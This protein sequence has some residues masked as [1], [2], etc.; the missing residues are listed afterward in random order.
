MN[1]RERLLECSNED[2]TTGFRPVVL[3]LLIQVLPG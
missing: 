2:K 3:V 1:M